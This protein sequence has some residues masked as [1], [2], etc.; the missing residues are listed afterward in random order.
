MRDL[1]NS[2]QIDA[3]VWEQRSALERIDEAIAR[4]L[5]PML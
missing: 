1:K 4:S 3:K 2:E 5:K